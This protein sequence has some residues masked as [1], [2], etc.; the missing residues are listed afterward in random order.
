MYFPEL[1]AIGSR[2]PGAVGRGQKGRRNRATYM[3]GIP[4]ETLRCSQEREMG[5]EC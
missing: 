2:F 3:V 1:E 4:G 5:T